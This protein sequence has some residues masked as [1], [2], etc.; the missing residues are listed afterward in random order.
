[1]IDALPGR[2]AHILTPLPGLLPFYALGGPSRRC[3][4]GYERGTMLRD[5]SAVLNRKETIWPRASSRDRSAE[6]TARAEDQAILLSLTFSRELPLRI[7]IE[8]ANGT[9]QPRPK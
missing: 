9:V 5:S 4:N 6:E 3:S 2:R 1:M 7:T 8:Y